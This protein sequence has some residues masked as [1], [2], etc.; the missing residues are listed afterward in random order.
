MIK[1]LLTL[2]LLLLLAEMTSAGGQLAIIIDD[3][4]NN[5]PLGRRATDLKGDFTLAIL[6]FT[7]H[8]QELADRAFSQGKEVILHVPM[9][10][11]RELPLG[12]GG[13]YSGMRREVFLSSLRASLEQ[14]PHLLGVNNHMGSQLTQE[15]EPMG[16]LM[17][18]L[19]E[20]GLYFID[21][22][23]SIESQALTVAR[24]YQLPSMK[25]DIFLDNSRDIEQIH[26][27]LLKVIKLA[28]RQGKAIAIGH[29]YPETLKVLE[30]IPTLMKKFKVELVPVSQLLGANN[31]NWNSRGK[32]KGYCRAPPMTLWHRP[33]PLLEPL[34]VINL[35]NV[36]QFSYQY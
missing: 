15:V 31:P 34:D 9:S 13:L 28:K 3:L 29:P 27:Q 24:I 23:T 20:R 32:Q 35:V 4:G 33:F 8:T 25:R 21:S 7:P 2:F 10:N 18:E 5:G 6:P 36:W 30:T 14:I 16:W 22:R 26:Q 1:R 17:H 12:K 19:A 11:T